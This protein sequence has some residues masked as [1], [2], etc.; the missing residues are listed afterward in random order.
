MDLASLGDPHNF[1]HVS[2]SPLAGGLHCAAKISTESCEFVLDARRDC[3]E[4]D[5]PH[6]PVRSQFFQLL[7]Q[8]LL[9]DGADQTAEIG[10]TTTFRVKVV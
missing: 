3:L 7:T 2:Y 5:A 8:H 4:I 10:E 6:E 9:A 1:T